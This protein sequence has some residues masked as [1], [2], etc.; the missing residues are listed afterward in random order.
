MVV[1]SVTVASFP[2]A[3]KGVTLVCLEVGN[4]NDENIAR[5]IHP[6]RN[7]KRRKETSININ[8]NNQP[9]ETLLKPTR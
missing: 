5:A 6:K 9:I 3:D 4:I 1:D 8:T 2:F 7:E